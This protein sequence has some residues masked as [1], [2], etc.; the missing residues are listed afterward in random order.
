[1]KVIKESGKVLKKIK[2]RWWVKYMW[3]GLIVVLLKLSGL[4]Y[5]IDLLI[6]IK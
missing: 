4:N 3:F 1:M 5:I 6:I 2:I